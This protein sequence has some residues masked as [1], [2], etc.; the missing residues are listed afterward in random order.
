M[1][2]FIYSFLLVLFYW[3]FIRLVSLYL[4]QIFPLNSLPDSKT[5]LTMVKQIRQSI[6]CHFFSWKHPSERQSSVFLAQME[7]VPVKI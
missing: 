7:P 3:V 4:L 1:G 6:S 5:S 2:T